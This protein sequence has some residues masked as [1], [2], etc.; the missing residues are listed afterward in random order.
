MMR[1]ARVEGEEHYPGSN[2][3]CDFSESGHTET[4]PYLILGC[5]F[6]LKSFRVMRNGQSITAASAPLHWDNLGARL[7]TCKS[8]LTYEA[9]SASH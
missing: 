7:A 4:F 8:I 9:K 3:P 5:L 1:D 2:E 6:P